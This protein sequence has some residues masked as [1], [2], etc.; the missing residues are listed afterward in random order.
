MIVDDVHAFTERARDALDRAP[1]EVFGFVEAGADI[2]RATD[3]YQD[4]TGNLRASTEAVNVLDDPGQWHFQLTM[5][6]SYASYVNDLGFSRIDEVAG[7]G[8]IVRS[9][10]FRHLTVTVPRKIAGG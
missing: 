7:Q 8:G 10:I 4:R 2:L 9:Q 1:R 3:P 6:E 5:G